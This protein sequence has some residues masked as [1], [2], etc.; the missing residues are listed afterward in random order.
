[1]AS[2]NILNPGISKI[3]FGDYDKIIIVDGDYKCICRNRSYY[4]GFYDCDENGN[5]LETGRNNSN[6]LCCG[7]CGRIFDKRTLEIK[8]GVYI[9]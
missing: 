2:Y 9:R 3:D 7:F 8:R 5:Q 4:I 1:M 6:L